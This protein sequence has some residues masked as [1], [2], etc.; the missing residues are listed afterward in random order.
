MGVD[1]DN[2]DEY[3]FFD[4]QLTE[5]ATGNVHR[6]AGLNWGQRA[7][8][9]PNQAYIPVS[10]RVHNLD[11]KFFPPR[12]N[13]FEI[14]TDDGNTLVCKMAQDYRKAIQT[15]QNNSIMGRYFRT[16]LGVPLGERVENKHL[17]DYGK[18]GVRIYKIDNNKYYMDFSV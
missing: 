10:K 14:H 6:R 11:P 5:R 9:E 1:L 17:R 12:N 18:Y 13:V 3:S 15:C 2:L 8:R 7:G 16:R 4:L